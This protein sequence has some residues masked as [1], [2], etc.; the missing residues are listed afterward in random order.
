M[1]LNRYP[2]EEFANTAFVHGCFLFWTKLF[3]EV[4]N[5]KLLAVT[6]ELVFKIW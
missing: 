1:K 5:F 2:P 3:I 4:P 6:P